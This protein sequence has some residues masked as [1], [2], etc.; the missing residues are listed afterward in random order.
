M[1]AVEWRITYGW[2][3]LRGNTLSQISFKYIHFLNK[4]Y[5]TNSHG[6][7]RESDEG[8]QTKEKFE[9]NGF[10]LAYCLWKNE[11]YYWILKLYQCSGL[12]SILR[13][14]EN[15]I[16]KILSCISR[17]LCPPSPIYVFCPVFSTRYLLSMTSLYEICQRCMSWESRYSF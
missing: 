7:Q 12:E 3:W 11:D 14:H 8:A 2:K 1:I 15:L 17:K 4:Q 5:T 9:R 16:V 13:T 10:A 6:Q